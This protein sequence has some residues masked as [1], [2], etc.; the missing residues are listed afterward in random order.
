[1]EYKKLSLRILKHHKQ[2]PLRVAIFLIIPI[3]RNL[4]ILETELGKQL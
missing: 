1:M 4:Q 3:L 2:K